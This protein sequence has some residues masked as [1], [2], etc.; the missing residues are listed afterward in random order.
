MHGKLFIRLSQL[1]T[2]IENY[3]YPAPLSLYIK[4]Y[5]TAHK[6][7]GSKDRKE[8]KAWL[9]AFFKSD[10]LNEGLSLETE[11]LHVLKND[12]SAILQSLKL[13]CQYETT[14]QAKVTFPLSGYI[15]PM[16]KTTIDELKE[17]KLVWLRFLQ[18]DCMI[19]EESI[20]LEADGLFGL[21]PSTAIAI[22]DTSYQIQDW[23]SYMAAKKCAALIK[24]S[25]V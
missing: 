2:L 14:A 25:M 19:E 20:V 23:A 3:P 9:Y 7:L 13:Q 16:V 4:E 1:K 12:A 11:L 8:I 22:P 10:F 15:S 6:N 17:E 24:G 18:Q 5:F 21:K